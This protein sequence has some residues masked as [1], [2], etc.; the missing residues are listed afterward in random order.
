MYCMHC[1]SKMEPAAQFCA[2]CGKPAA[3]R[4]VAAPQRPG[5]RVTRHIR[6]LG[7]L[8]IVRGGLKLLGAAL[9][10][11]FGTAMLPWMSR[12]MPRFPLER[13]MEGFIPA[14][15]ALSAGLAF[16]VGAASVV[17]GIGLLQHDPIGRPLALILGFLSLLSIPIGTALGIYTLWVLLPAQ[18]GVEYRRLAHTS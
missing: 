12:I 9:A 13:F 15:I 10:F 14:M 2:S 6:I 4:A 18:S 17:A 1:G 3:A 5:E 7:V 16:V 8:W 11:F